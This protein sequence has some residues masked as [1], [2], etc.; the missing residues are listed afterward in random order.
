MRRMFSRIC[1]ATLARRVVRVDPEDGHAEARE[2]AVDDLLEDGAL[3][4]EVEIEGAAR[5]A[6]GGDDVVDLRGVVAAL[7]EDVA[8]VVQDLLAPLG[9]VHSMTRDESRE[10]ALARCTTFA[11]AVSEKSTRSP[12][13]K[14]TRVSVNGSAV[15]ARGIGLVRPWVGIRLLALTRQSSR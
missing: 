15:R 11:D 4:L 9:L 1:V 2:D 12:S 14:L 5:D 10:R 3:V 8:R 13:P 6:R 7:G